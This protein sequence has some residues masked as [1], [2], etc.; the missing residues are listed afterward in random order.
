MYGR[1]CKHMNGIKITLGTTSTL[2]RSAVEEACKTLGLDLILSAVK[3]PS[4]QNEQ[5]AG[6]T[7]IYAGAL[8]RAQLAKEKADDTIA[9]GIENGIIRLAHNSLTLEF[10]MIVVLTPEDREIVV[11]SPGIV[12]PEQYVREAKSR[13]FEKNTVGRVI[14]E[15]LGGDHQDPHSILSKGKITRK[16]TLVSALLLALKQI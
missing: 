2:K 12:F 16:E 11:S 4:G 8:N 1:N 5:P 6:F 7:E 14:A 13:G 15:K 3:V 9:I 10:A